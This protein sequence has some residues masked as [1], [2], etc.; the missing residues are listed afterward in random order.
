MNIKVNIDRSLVFTTPLPTMRWKYT[1][2]FLN[3]VLHCSKIIQ[4]LTVYLKK[5]QKGVSCH[6]ILLFFILY[7]YE[8]TAWWITAF[9]NEV[10]TSH[11][12]L[13][14]GEKVLQDIQE[15]LDE[16]LAVKAKLPHA[17]PY[18][19]TILSNECDPRHKVYRNSSSVLKKVY[20]KPIQQNSWADRKTF[21]S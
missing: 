2:F 6:A 5:R 17:I 8:Y 19:E 21:P 12:K 10:Y 16:R 20:S 15:E 13:D 1:Y 11:C 3:T 7:S 9:N 18:Q 14:S 4:S